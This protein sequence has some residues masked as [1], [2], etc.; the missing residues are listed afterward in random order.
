M[1]KILILCFIF[2]SQNSYSQFF[3]ETHS[4]DP[5]L[6]GSTWTYGVFGFGVSDLPFYV[7]NSSTSED[8]YMKIQ[9]VSAVNADGSLAQLCF[10]LCYEDLVIG[11]SYPPGAETVIIN[12]GENQGFPGDKI[13][14]L[15]DG[16]G[17][18]VEYVFRFYQVDENGNPI[19]GS[20]DLTMTYRYDP[21]LA[22]VDHEPQLA[23]TQNLVVDQ[24]KIMAQER[25]ELDLF[26]LQGKHVGRYEINQGDQSIDVSALA[27]A[28]YIMVAT[29]NQGQQKTM[30]IIKR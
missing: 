22:I 30:K 18:P 5:I 25:L 26:T 23:L 6:D 9:F 20:D 10:G 21:N 8:I 4:G 12:P 1:K 24:L 3:V 29:N 19:G 27:S 14:N 16:N 28:M 15:S 7:Y 13:V 2:F 11:S 17:N